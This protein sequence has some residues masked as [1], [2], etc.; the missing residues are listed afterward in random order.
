LGHHVGTFLFGFGI[1]GPETE[2]V[3]DQ[4]YCRQN[5]NGKKNTMRTL[6]YFHYNQPFYIDEYSGISAVTSQMNSVL[7]LSQKLPPKQT[8]RKKVK[9]RLY[10][11]L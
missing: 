4:N 2:S 1:P 5:K 10:V 7:I 6:I 3:G 11:R 8:G 9:N